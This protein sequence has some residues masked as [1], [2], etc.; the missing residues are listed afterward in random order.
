M[1]WDRNVSLAAGIDLPL[2]LLRDDQCAGI[3]L[4]LKLFRDDQCVW[5]NG[6]SEIFC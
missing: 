2:K 1:G 5:D 3:D 4:P 6:C